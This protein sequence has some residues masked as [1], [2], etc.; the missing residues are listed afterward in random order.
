MFKQFISRI[1]YRHVAIA[2]GASIGG[3]LPNYILDKTENNTQEMV[4]ASGLG[5]L[6]G[7]ITGAG[8]LAIGPVIILPI[9]CMSITYF[10][11]KPEPIKQVEQG[12]QKLIKII[13]I[14]EYIKEQQEDVNFVNTVIGFVI[15]S[16]IVIIGITLLNR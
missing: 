13:M 3:I 15:T 14:N 8:I 6:L 2:T 9:G 11:N 12:K 4:I 16:S 10:N 7:G 5:S 1:E